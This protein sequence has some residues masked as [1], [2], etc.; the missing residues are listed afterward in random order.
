MV[1]GGMYV[2]MCLYLRLV[3]AY[4]VSV[5]MRSLPLIPFSLAQNEWLNS[6]GSVPL[7]LPTPGMSF[8]VGNWG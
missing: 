1:F 4:D 8:F 2:C 7:F 6:Y 3:T 5:C